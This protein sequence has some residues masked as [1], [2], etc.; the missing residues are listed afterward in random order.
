MVDYIKMIQSSKSVEELDSV[1]EQFDAKRLK[2]QFWASRTIYLNTKKK[3]EKKKALAT[4]RYINRVF[5]STIPLSEKIEPFDAPN[6]F[7]GIHISASATIGRGCTIMP[8]AMIVRDSFYDSDGFGAPKIGIN[9]FIGAGACIR[10]K[11]KVGNNVRIRE[12]VVVS[13]NV[14]NNTEVCSGKMEFKFHDT[15]M[16]NRVFLKK[17]ENVNYST[18]APVDPDEGPVPNCILKVLELL[19]CTFPDHFET[20]MHPSE[21]VIKKPSIDLKTIASVCRGAIAESK[22]KYWYKKFSTQYESQRCYKQNNFDL[23]VWF[24]DWALN[25]YRAGYSIDNYFDFEF[26]R[27]PLS[28]RFTFFSTELRNKLINVANHAPNHGVLAVN[29][30]VFNRMYADFIHREWLVSTKCTEKKFLAFCERHPSF[31][32][33][34][35]KGEGG[36]G[37]R[38]I[39][40]KGKDLHKLFVQLSKEETIMEELVV[41]HE[42]LAQVNPTS[43]NTVRINT[44]LLPGGVPKIIAAAGRFGRKG[45]VV[46]NF[47]SGGLVVVVD[48]ETGIVSS[49]AYDS[50]HL[51]YPTHPDSGVQFRG[52]QYPLWD[53]LIDTVKR[54]AVA[55]GGSGYTGWDIAITSNNQ[56]ELIEK[57]GRSSTSLSQMDQIGKRNLFE[58]CLIEMEKSL[59]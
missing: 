34:P 15:P 3:L 21:Y 54:A 46:D 11:V 27:K 52:F 32:A 6:G 17:P 35:L 51:V 59:Q 50:T 44:V 33:K 47:H 41:Q 26:Y 1:L 48:P 45:G 37:A 2:E 25:M 20:Y 57:N 36:H 58:P 53:T 38:V 43:L 7:G 8:N 55:C 56:I 29:K 49:D 12:N 14:P 13:G 22:I 16:D 19:D 39:D 24:C 28:E 10:G 5:G 4:C 42:K 31:F 9:V 30:G 18:T 40:T 23:Q